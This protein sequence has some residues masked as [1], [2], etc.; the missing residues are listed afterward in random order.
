MKKEKI[1]LAG[2][3]GYLGQYVLA[4]LLRK[5]YPTRIVVRN[6]AKSTCPTHTPAIGSG[7]SSSN[8]T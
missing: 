2:A 5:E 3:T 1:L 8:P 4:E 7:R 6:K